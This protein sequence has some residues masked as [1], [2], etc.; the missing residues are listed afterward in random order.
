MSDEAKITDAGNPQ[1]YFI[2]IPNIVDEMDLSVHAFRLYVHFKRRAWE[3]GECFESTKTLATACGMSMSTVSEAKKE[4]A[5]AGLITIRKESRGKAGGRESDVIE[6]VDIWPENFA[7]YA[8][9]NIEQEKGA[10]SPSEVGATSQDEL[11]TSPSEPIKNPLIKNNPRRMSYEDFVKSLSR[12]YPQLTFMGISQAERLD[13]LFREHGPERLRAI[14][15]WMSTSDMRLTSMPQYLSFC[16]KRAASWG[17]GPPAPREKAPEEYKRDAARY[18]LDAAPDTSDGDWDAGLFDENLD[19]A[20]A[21][22]PAPKPQPKR[23]PDYWDTL[24]DIIITNY[25]IPKQS[26][27]WLLLSSGRLAGIRDGTMTVRIADPELATGR[28]GAIAN[29]YA[30]ALNGGS[31][32]RVAFVGAEG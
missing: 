19:D 30:P 4:L 5:E 8:K 21:V 16:E 11:A 6:I 28:F 2:S 1:K 22:P 15:D 14:A 10:T 13:D 31:I 3:R 7:R 24:R 29:N 25:Q 18:G 9:A 20:P 32:A 27:F 17:D 26:K 12:Q 23:E